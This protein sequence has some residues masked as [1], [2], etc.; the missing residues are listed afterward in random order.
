MLGPMV[1]GIAYCPIDRNDDLK[2]LGVDDS[3]V[4]KESEREALF[5]KLL[6]DSA[7]EYVGWAIHVL[8]PRYVDY[9]VLH[10]IF[11]GIYFNIEGQEIIAIF[12]CFG[13]KKRVFEQ[14]SKTFQCAVNF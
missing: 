11:R 2:S 13:A 9:A 8:S 4:L 3:K 12:L 1:Y 14:T 10:H 7:A 5:D 6:E